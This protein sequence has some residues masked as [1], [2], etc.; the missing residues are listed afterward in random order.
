MFNSYMDGPNQPASG[1]GSRQVVTAA[2]KWPRQAARQAFFPIFSYIY[3]LQFQKTEIW[4]LTSIKPFLLHFLIEPFTE[5]LR[6]LVLFN[7]KACI[8][9]FDRSNNW[10]Q[11]NISLNVLSRFKVFHKLP[12]NVFLL[13]SAVQPGILQAYPVKILH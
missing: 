3:E 8:K 5:N 6:L 9:R 12:Q 7:T 1:D 13:S 2:G 4:L 11:K 10:Q